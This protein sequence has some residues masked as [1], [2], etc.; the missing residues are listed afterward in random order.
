M[1]A[2]DRYRSFM[3]TYEYL[4]ENHISETARIA[5]VDPLQSIG[6][7]GSPLALNLLKHFHA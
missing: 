6:L 2:H 3:L 5:A 1:G 4:Y 7:P